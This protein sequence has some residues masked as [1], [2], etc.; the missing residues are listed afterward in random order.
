MLKRLNLAAKMALVIGAVLSFILIVL[1]AVTVT[2]SGSAISDSI[3]GEL[4]SVSKENALQIQQIFNAAETISSNMQS[5]MEQAYELAD[6]DPSQMTLPTQA[7][8]IEMCKSGIY[9]KVLT[10]LNYD[11]EVFLRETARNNAE[12]NDDIAG[13]GV[14]F[15]P[16]AFQDNMRNF[17]FYV[18]EKS[19]SQ[20][21]IPYGVHE[22]YSRE[23]YYKDAMEAKTAVVTDPYDH[24]GVTLV[25][26]ASPIMR[27]GQPQGV[28]MAD[29]NITNFSKVDSDNERYPSMYAAIYNSSA[30]I[31][32]SSENM[33]DIG[34]SLSD[35][36]PNQSEFQ[37]VLGKMAEGSAFQVETTRED[38]RK[39]TR[40]FTPIKAANETWWSQ[41]AVDTSD[42]NEAVNKTGIWMIVLSL[43]ALV[44]IILTVVVLLR[45][46]LSPMKEIVSAA[47]EIA[48]GHL[49]VQLKAD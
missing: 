30:K 3:S 43:V 22:T 11:V 2:M 46:M 19:A 36:M 31:I 10:P 44:A 48:A 33:A 42:M 15:E 23:T 18:D 8:A 25:T 32:Y 7:E 40:F 14:M 26:Y 1:I 4:S 5:Y 49:E 35:F 27:N 29:I 13:V 38:G 17:A 16:Y 24:D 21:V 34:K 12:F 41:T 20:D 37:M 6:S 47:E 39:V 45:N 28:A 9:D